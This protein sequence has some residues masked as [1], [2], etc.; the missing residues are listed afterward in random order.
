VLKEKL[1]FKPDI[2][3]QLPADEKNKLELIK[4]YS[5]KEIEEAVERLSMIIT[6]YIEKIL[7]NNKHPSKATFYDLG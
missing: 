7:R 1:N 6:K 2:L 4:E 5:P 3:D